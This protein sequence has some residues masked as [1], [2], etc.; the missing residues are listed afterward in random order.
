MPQ[1]IASFLIALVLGAAP[2]APGAQATPAALARFEVTIAMTSRM[3]R[4]QILPGRIAA[5]RQITVPGDVTLAEEPSGWK[6]NGPGVLRTIKLQAVFETTGRAPVLRVVLSKGAAGKALVEVRNTTGAPFMAARLMNELPAGGTPER[7]T[8]ALTAILRRTRRQLLGAHDPPMPLADPRRLVLANYYPWFRVG[9]YGSAQLTDRPADPRSTQTYEDVLAMTQQASDAGVD[10]FVSSWAGQQRSGFDLDL[11]L[12]AAEATGSVVTPYFETVEAKEESEGTRTDPRLV[13][14]WMS[15]ALAHADHPAFLRVD[16]VPVVFVY[17]MP[18]LN[19]VGWE[20]V[21]GELRKRGQDVRL[22]GDA[23]MASHGSV[24]WG[25][26]EYNPNSMTPEQLTLSNRSLMLDA[27]LLGSNDVA[28]PHIYVATV[29]PGFDDTALRGDA[30][31]VVPRGE[32]G[33]RYLAT[34]AAA[35]AAAPD[36]IMITSWNEWFEGT[37]IEPSVEFGDLALRQTAEQAAAFH[38]S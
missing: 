12:R 16:G 3:A 5:T 38:A 17:A 6:V 22:V 19:R 10:G 9:S 21:V 34:W 7:N 32:N 36:W 4:V 18:Q 11:A 26:Q 35:R 37:S 30:N 14:Q 28:A 8:G 15:E 25:V 13:L 24:Q 29:S 31:P 2:F 27:R 20:Y 23:R 1:Q 33:E